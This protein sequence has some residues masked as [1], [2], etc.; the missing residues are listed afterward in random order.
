MAGETAP[1]RTAFFLSET[2]AMSEFTALVS[3]D[4][5]RFGLC[6]ATLA[7]EGTSTAPPVFFRDPAA[8]LACVDFAV[9]KDGT[10][11]GGDLPSN[12][13]KGDLRILAGVEAT[14][15]PF[16]NFDFLVGKPWCLLW[17]DGLAGGG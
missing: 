3:G 10:P 5:W 15:T 7:G 8:L 9:E 14:D 6:K 12:A 2:N 11:A 4:L 1:L 16:L 17:C 13:F